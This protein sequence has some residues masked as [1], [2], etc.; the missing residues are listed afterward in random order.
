MIRIE[1]RFDYKCENELRKLSRSAS[2]ICDFTVISGAALNLPYIKR[3][4]V[5]TLHKTCTSDK[6]F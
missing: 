5:F 6:F 1:A 2:S 3:G 4:K